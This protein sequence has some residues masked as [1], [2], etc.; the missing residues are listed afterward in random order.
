MTEIKIKSELPPIRCDICHQMDMFNKETNICT[1]CKDIKKETV[2]N[3][4]PNYQPDVIKDILQFILTNK[5]YNNKRFGD[6][7]IRLIREPVMPERLG[8]RPFDGKLAALEIERL[9]PGQT[10]VAHLSDTVFR[11]E[12]ISGRE[13]PVHHMLRL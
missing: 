8:G 3:E 1:R 6:S 2:L 12:H 9:I 13:I 7:H 4:A 5:T 11:N 10:E